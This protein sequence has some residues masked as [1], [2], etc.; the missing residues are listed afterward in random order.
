M[1]RTETTMKRIV[2]L[3]TLFSFFLVGFV[4]AQAPAVPTVPRSVGFAGMNV[5]LDED[6]RAVVQADVKA[7]LGNKK[8]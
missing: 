4:V 6:A 8:Y 2:A 1:K 5:Q 3:T 7:L